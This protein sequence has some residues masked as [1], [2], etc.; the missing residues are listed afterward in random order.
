M[1]IV[2]KRERWEQDGGG[3]MQC[4]TEANEKTQ[5]GWVN[6]MTLQRPRCSL[7]VA[8]FV[9]AAVSVRSS[10]SISSQQQHQFVAA[11]VSVEACSRVRS[12]FSSQS[13]ASPRLI[14]AISAIYASASSRAH[15]R[16][17][18]NVTEHHPA[19]PHHVHCHTTFTATPTTR[20]RHAGRHH[21]ALPK[22]RHAYPG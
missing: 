7:A 15:R 8:V 3:G 19:P 21:V 14:A 9:V 18:C 13:T 22:P 11:A 5:T 1:G 2:I 20:H 10:S 16:A 12:S 6:R 17:K 4:G